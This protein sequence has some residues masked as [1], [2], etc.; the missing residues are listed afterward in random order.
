MPSRNKKKCDNAHEMILLDLC[1]ALRHLD[2]L[3]GQTTPDDI[4]NLSQETNITLEIESDL[5]REARIPAA[6]EGTSISAL[7]AARPGSSC[8]SGRTLR[9]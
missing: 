2:H 9:A 8:G 7:V 6:K 4:L 1:S 3:T 5:L